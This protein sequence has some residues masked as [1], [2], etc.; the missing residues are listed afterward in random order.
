MIGLMKIVGKRSDSAATRKMVADEGHTLN[1]CDLVV[2][3][4]PFFGPH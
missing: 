2:S 3:R 1:R 4:R